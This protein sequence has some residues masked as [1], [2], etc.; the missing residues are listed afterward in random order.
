MKN[1]ESELKNGYIKEE[2]MKIISQKNKD[3]IKKN[4]EYIT[5]INTGKGYY[6]ITNSNLTKCDYNK[7]RIY[8]QLNR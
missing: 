1:L 4:W 3:Y 8:C 6:L 7:T 2:E 5:N